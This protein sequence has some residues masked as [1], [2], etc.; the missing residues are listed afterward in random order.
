MITAKV[1]SLLVRT[2]GMLI[3][4]SELPTLISFF[5]TL[6]TGVPEVPACASEP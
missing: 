4:T 6:E 2:S 3:S 1:L 5:C